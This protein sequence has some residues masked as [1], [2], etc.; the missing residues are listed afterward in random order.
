MSKPVMSNVQKFDIFIDIIK[1]GSNS[2]RKVVSIGKN[3]R[4][5]ILLK[6]IPW[7]EMSNISKRNF[8][9]NPLSELYPILLT[10]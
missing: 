3:S 4:T 6:T 2:W 10:K 7:V 1:E 9:Q 8:G 5:T